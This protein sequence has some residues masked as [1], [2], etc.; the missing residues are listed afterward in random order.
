MAGQHSD[1]GQ[2]RANARDQIDRNRTVGDV[3]ERA[4]IA[5]FTAVAEQ[6]RDARPDIVIGSG[7]D[8][9][10][11][12]IGPTVIS[13]DT[14]VQGRHFRLEWSAAQQIGARTVIQSA[15][16][17][18]AMGGR[19]VG[20]VASLACPAE[21][22]VG[23]LLDLD[24][25]IVDMTHQLGAR[26]LG[27]DLVQADEVV[28]SI[29]AIGALDGLSAVTL[30]GAQAGDVL[31]VSGALGAA[32]AGLAVL[33]RSGAD[34]LDRWQQAGDPR[35]AVVEAFRVP[36]PDLGEG[37]VAAR[38]GA[39]AMTDVS[40]GLVEEIITMATASG[41]T[42]NVVAG[43]VPH[44]SETAA[45]AGLLGIDLAQWVMAG[46]EDHVLLGAFAPA[47]VPAGWVVIGEVSDGPPIA[48]VDHQPATEF[49]GWQSFG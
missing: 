1:A 48:L 44:T 36:R 45:V 20:I 35:A 49:A 42:L 26:V 28:V 14:A 12:D 13:T 19:T 9:A 5:S 38:A 16:D 31:A 7:D 40:D 41:L 33:S 4:L 11:L 37:V 46:G 3:G 8:A 21:T 27:G 25:G 23:W 30:S 43:D 29:T 32:A 24:E 22:P 15:A 18:A 17:I 2:R 34:P 10:V 39:H 47:D 6:R